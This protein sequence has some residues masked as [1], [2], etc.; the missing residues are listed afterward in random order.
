MRPFDEAG[1]TAQRLA[2][3]SVPLLELP[4]GCY[5][6]PK[7]TPPASLPQATSPPKA[8]TPAPSAASSSRPSPEDVMRAAG[9]G[10]HPQI[11]ADGTP[12]MSMQWSGPHADATPPPPQFVAAVT[13][14]YK[15]VK[16]LDGQVSDMEGQ[17]SEKVQGMI[18]VLQKGISNK[19]PSRTDVYSQFK[20]WLEKK[21]NADKKKEH[22]AMLPDEKRQFRID[23]AKKRLT[24][25][26]EIHSKTECYKRVD[27]TQGTYRSLGRII[28]EGR[29][30]GGMRSAS[31]PQR[32]SGESSGMIILL[33]IPFLFPRQPPP[34]LF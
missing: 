27:F 22:D 28:K 20:R 15:R 8:A 34:S 16:E 11:E 6:P 33:L 7:D 21:V 14:A 32:W 3:G 9:V 26:K 5:Q 10:E 24:R 13:A 31:G 2:H 30:W 12:Q 19:V 25:V 17:F 29:V 18:D 1:E 23:W 4:P